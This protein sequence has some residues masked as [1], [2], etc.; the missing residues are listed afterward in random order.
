MLWREHWRFMNFIWNSRTI[1]E[2]YKWVTNLQPLYNQINP[3]TVPS[4]VTETGVIFQD[5]YF[6]DICQVV[7]T[8]YS[9]VDL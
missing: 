2:D 5:V 9:S 1:I 6:S 7:E 4:A 3:F 8:F